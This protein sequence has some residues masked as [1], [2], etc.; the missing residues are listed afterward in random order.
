MWQVPTD[1]TGHHEEED[2]EEEEEEEEE[3]GGGG[4]LAS[5]GREARCGVS[6]KSVARALARE[7][8]AMARGSMQDSVPPA[9]AMSASPS[10]MSL[11][12]S[13]MLCAPAAHAVTKAAGCRH[14]GSRFMTQ[15]LGL[16]FRV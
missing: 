1:S 3:G 11:A 2:E 10:A 7:K 12:A 14:Q 13:M 4:D 6:L 5:N 8:P 9:S 16:G 15:G